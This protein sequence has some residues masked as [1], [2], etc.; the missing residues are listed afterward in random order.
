MEG[1]RESVRGAAFRAPQ[2]RQ[3]HDP[4]KVTARPVSSHQILENA[5]SIVGESGQQNEGTKRWRL[6][7]WNII[8]N[9]TF[10]GPSFWTGRGFGIN[11]GDADGFG[12]SGDS[13]PPV[14]R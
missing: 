8:I 12:W 13:G 5:K 7:W 10:Y 9:E 11:L 6:N 1:F 14:S 2:P 4:K 3:T